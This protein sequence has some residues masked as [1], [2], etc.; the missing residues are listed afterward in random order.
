MAIDENSITWPRDHSDLLN[1]ANAVNTAERAQDQLALGNITVAEANIRMVIGE[2]VRVIR[3]PIPRAIRAALNA[4]VKD[5][6]LGHM[7]KDGRKPEVYYRPQQRAKAEQIRRR[8]E[9]HTLVALACVCA[10]PPI[11]I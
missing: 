6:R 1:C 10:P 8:E 5:G 11:D 7:R 9:I 2:G 3:G 4:A